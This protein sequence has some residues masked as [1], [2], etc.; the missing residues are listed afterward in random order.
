LGVVPLDPKENGNVYQKV[1]KKFITHKLEL[2]KT[3]PPVGKNI[4]IQYKKNDLN[5]FRYNE[6]T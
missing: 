2:F 5:F 1:E 3:K 6:A 4:S